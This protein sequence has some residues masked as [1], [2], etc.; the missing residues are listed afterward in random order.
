MSMCAFNAERDRH[1]FAP[2]PLS[3]SQNPKWWSAATGEVTDTP[4]TALPPTAPFK[5]LKG[6]QRA[7]AAREK[8]TSV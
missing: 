7:K 1:I 5:N 4:V 2:I 3:Q 6:R 8:E